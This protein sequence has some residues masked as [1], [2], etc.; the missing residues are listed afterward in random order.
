MFEPLCA[1]LDAA[2]IACT[3][4]EL[5]ADHCTF[6]IGGPADIFIKPCDEIQLCRA[7][8]FCKEQGVRYYLLGNGSNILF[9]DAGFRGAVLDLTAMK[10]GIGMK[11]NIPGEESGVVY[12]NVTVGAGMKL[13]TL[14]N[15]ALNHSCTG[16]EFAYGI[17][18][19]VGGAIYM[20]AGAYGG[21]MKDILE[22]VT[23]L[24][25]KGEQKKL[26]KEE[27]QLGYRTSV[28]KEKGYIVLEAV[29]NLTKGDPEAIKSRMDELKEQRVTKQPLEY[30]SAG[31]TFK[32][33]EGYFAG[34]LIQD[35]GLRGYQVGGAQVSEKHCGFVINKE[36]ATATDVVNLIH[37]V[38]RI[39]YEKFQVQLDTEVKFL[40]EF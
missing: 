20:N 35:A 34:K 16:L 39:V 1:A 4:N 7:V 2:G 9:E 31:S 40:G 27:L 36:N 17:P 8:A 26:Y 5:L 28:V 15:F 25:P 10:T 32:R 21:E 19:T 37:D 33:P 13:S 23:V 14:C 3:R 18:G 12:C 24:T 29:L 22:S 30:P 6:R 11:E 38:Q